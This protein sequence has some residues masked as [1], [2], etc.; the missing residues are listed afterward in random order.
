MKKSQDAVC[1]LRD[2]IDVIGPFKV[3]GELD[4]QVWVGR[5]FLEDVVVQGVTEG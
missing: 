5:N 1:F 3:L 2:A 4:F